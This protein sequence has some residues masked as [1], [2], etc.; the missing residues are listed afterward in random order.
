MHS[1]GKQGQIL[2][3][4]ALDKDGK[5]EKKNRNRYTEQEKND[6]FKYDGKINNWVQL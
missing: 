2:V 1:N 4:Q 3:P 5:G 6:K